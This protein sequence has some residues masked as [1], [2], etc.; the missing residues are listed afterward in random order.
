M[1]CLMISLS[2]LVIEIP[3]A[4]EEKKALIER[5]IVNSKS[6]PNAIVNTTDGLRVEFTDH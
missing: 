5:L 3:V 1:T 4:E 6:I 2:V